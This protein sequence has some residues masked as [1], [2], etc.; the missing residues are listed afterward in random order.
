VVI[1][2]TNVP[3]LRSRFVD[4]AVE[5]KAGQTLA[6]AGLLQVR[7]EASSVGVAGLADIPYLGALFRKNTEVQNEVEL[8][9]LVTPNFASPMDPHE[10]PV[11]GPGYNSGSPLDKEL[12][13]KGYI[14]TPN[15]CGPQGDCP[16]C[17]ENSNGVLYDNAYA[18]TSAANGA[19]N[20]AQVNNMALKGT[21]LHQNASGF[22]R[23]QTPK[24]PAATQPAA[25]V[26]G[27]RIPSSRR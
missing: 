4:T 15:A 12:F 2:G 21:Q 27:N 14:E 18:P 22:S 16:P 17:T 11:G 6:L 25:G 13:M 20:G 26:A 3:G 10:V 1:N 8:L 23:A 9:I 5:L 7:T 24:A 19:A